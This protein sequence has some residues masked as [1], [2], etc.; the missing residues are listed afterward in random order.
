M[1]NKTQIRTIRAFYDNPLTSKLTAKFNGVIDAADMP[2]LD[3]KL[4][5]TAKTGTATP[6]GVQVIDGGSNCIITYNT[7]IEIH[8]VDRLTA[9]NTTDKGPKFY[10]LPVDNRVHVI[11]ATGGYSSDDWD[12]KMVVGTDGGSPAEYGFI[13]NVTGEIVHPTLKSSRNRPHLTY[14]TIQEDDG[15]M[16]LECGMDGTDKLFGKSCTLEI[17]GMG[18]AV[19]PLRLGWSEADKQYEMHDIQ[20]GYLGDTIK[21]LVGATVGFSITPHH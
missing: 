6:T 5:G 7:N 1:S 15:S 2:D 21:E 14:F 10:G 11:G 16:R 17:E 18:R 4:N 13:A 9:S 12:Y 19:V 20:I 8:P 3:L